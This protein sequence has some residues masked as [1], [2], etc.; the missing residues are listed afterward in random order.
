M[1]RLVLVVVMACGG[2]QAAAPAASHEL[3]IDATRTHGEHSRDAGSETDS[4]AVRGMEVSWTVTA[5][6]GYR[7]HVPAGQGQV[8]LTDEQA[9][10]LTDDATAVLAGA[11]IS[12]EPIGMSFE[13]WTI[14]VEVGGR[15]ADLA[16]QNP[17]D[18][19][20]LYEE[21]GELLSALEDLKPQ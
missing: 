14:H 10:K 16:Y 17:T 20:P 3:R 11:H 15:S 13:T 8:T 6:G 12:R 9:K 7:D 19:D 1:R 21:A 5:D 4:F 2:K 18:G